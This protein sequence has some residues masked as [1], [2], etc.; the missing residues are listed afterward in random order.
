MVD[1]VRESKDL[2]G[3]R[4]MHSIRFLSGNRIYLGEQIDSQTAFR[5]EGTLF[6]FVRVSDDRLS[7]DR[8]L[9]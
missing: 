5:I 9:A 7:I 4:L 2:L 3:E 6:D 8:L 1:G